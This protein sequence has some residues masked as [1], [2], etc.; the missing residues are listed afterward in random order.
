MNRGFVICLL[1][2]LAACTPANFA[3]GVAD[4]ITAP[5]VTHANKTVL[6][7]QVASS[8][9]LLYKGFRI[10]GTLVIKSGQCTGTC[11]QTIRTL[12]NQAYGLLGTIR[13][14][15]KAGNAASYQEAYSDLVS[16]IAQGTALIAQVKGNH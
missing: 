6:D 3:T 4:A 7:E 15:Y 9:E 5:P 1:F 14:A 12:N 10:G 13:R 16:T 11:A 8:A 2:V